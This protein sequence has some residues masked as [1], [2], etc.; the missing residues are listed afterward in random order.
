MDVEVHLCRLVVAVRALAAATFPLELHLVVPLLREVLLSFVAAPVLG[1]LIRLVRVVEVGSPNLVDAAFLVRVDELGP[2]RGN[3][4]QVQVRHFRVWRVHEQGLRLNVVLLREQVAAINLHLAVNSAEVL[5]L[6]KR[7]V[8]HAL[9]A[10]EDWRFS[11]RSDAIIENLDCVFA[12]K[13]EGV[14]TRALH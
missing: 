13:L 5:P 12:P 6:L 10:F 1:H 3:S 2:R 8:V 4:L 7:R 11:D 9:D 14:D